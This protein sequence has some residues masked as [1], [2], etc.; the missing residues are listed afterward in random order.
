[1]MILVGAC[2]AGI[3]VIHEMNAGQA[4]VLRRTLQF[5]FPQLR[6]I[7][8]PFQTIS[9][10]VP[11]FSTGGTDEVNLHPASGIISQG[12]A[13]AKGLVIRMRQDCQ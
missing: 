10:H 2:H 8:E 4:E 13:R 12:A 5:V 9:V 7:R 3:T 6:D 11:G 1:M